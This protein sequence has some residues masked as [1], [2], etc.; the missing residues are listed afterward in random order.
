MFRAVFVAFGG[1]F[2]QNSQTKFFGSFAFFDFEKDKRQIQA[3]TIKYGQFFISQK[4]HRANS[5]GRRRRFDRT[6]ARFGRRRRRRAA[7]DARRFRFDVDGHRGNRRRGHL[8]NDW[9]GVVRRRTRRYIFI[10][11]YGDCLRFFRALLRGIRVAHSGRG[12]CLHIFLREFGRTRRVD[13]RLGF[14]RRIRHRQ[15]RRRHQLERLFYRTSAR[16]RHQHSA[17]FD[18]GLSDGEARIRG[19]FRSGRQRRN[20]R[21]FDGEMQ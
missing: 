14:N 8:R 4:I 7:P 9:Q 11:L 20:A 6:R 19:C 18:D 5:G 10:Y 21:V 2:R 13:Y 3:Q 1:V 17:Q 12:F 16:L 15:H